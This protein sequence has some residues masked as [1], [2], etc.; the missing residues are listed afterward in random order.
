MGWVVLGIPLWVTAQSLEF[1]SLKKLSTDVNTVSEEAMPLR[2]PD[3]KRLYFTRALYAGN[4]GGK[5]S[6]TDVWVSK[7]GGDGWARA[8]NSLSIRVNDSGHSVVVGMNNDG[9]KL[10]FVSAQTDKKMPGIY[11]TTQINSYWTRPELI[12]IPGIENQNFVGVYVS[13]DFDV[14]LLSMKASDSRGEE[15]LYFS[16]KDAAGR[17]SVPQSMGPTINTAGFEIS[18]FL[19]ADKRRLYFSSNGHGGEGDADIFYSDRLYNSWETW[20]VPVNLGKVVNSPKFDAYFSIYGD[21]VAY[22]CSNR[23]SKFADIYQ[24]SVSPTK[25]VLAPGQRYLSTREWNE[26]LGGAVAHEIVF[27]AGS[28][29]LTPP[30]KELLFY[31]GNKLQLRRSIR[32]HLVVVEEDDPQHTQA[33][34]DAIKRQL[35]QSGIAESRIITE[36]VEKPGKTGKGKVMIKLIE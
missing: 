23:E 35:T 21:S 28:T 15:D 36:Q 18:P 19:S 22:F 29:N 17:W 31:I 11:V 24:V 26:V 25:T 7:G 30:Q 2:S 8:S 16:V 32:F 33:R 12:S 6:G 14:I 5:F 10:Y 4:S 3:G 13:P 27:D 34:L 9:N 1:H 20:S